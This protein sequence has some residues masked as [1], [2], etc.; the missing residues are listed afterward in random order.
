MAMAYKVIGEEEPRAGRVLT[1]LFSLATAFAIFLIL[2][3]S[4]TNTAPY[5]AMALFLIAPMGAYLGRC[6]VRHPMAF[7]FQALAFLCW[8]IWLKKPSWTYW[9]GTW[10]AGAITILMN[11]ANAY[12]GIPMAFALILVRGWKGVW[13]RRVWGLAALMLLPSVLWLRHALEYGA[14]FLAPS[15]GAVKQRDLGRFLR[16]EWVNYEFFDAMDD[17]IRDLL[18]TP[19]GIALAVLGLCLFWRN[20]MAWLAKAWC[21]ASLLYLC[22]DH[23]VIYINPHDYYFVH[24]LIPFAMVGGIGAG[25]VVDGVKR[26]FPEHPGFS[27]AGAIAVLGLALFQSWQVYYFPQRTQWMET[28]VGPLQ[29]WLP[30][31][32]KIRELTDPDAPI[33]VDRPEDALIYYCDRPGWVEHTEGLT[34]EAFESLISHGAE[35]LLLTTYLM[36]GDSFTGYRFYNPPGEGGAPGAD[37]VSRNGVIIHEGLTFQI[38]DLQP[39]LHGRISAATPTGGGDSDG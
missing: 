16:L 17:G 3:I 4:F 14:V 12:I 28:E 21:F 33:V 34:Q 26:L 13:D 1:M 24:L 7:F 22:F 36:E 27:S 20:K 30:A 6:V 9:M 10:I 15:A 25:A 29:H 23:Y 8:L 32:E 19:V 2:R 5:W 39:A 38:V 37:W 18:L 31:S 11:F 35:Y